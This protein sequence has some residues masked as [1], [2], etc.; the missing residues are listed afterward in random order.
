MKAPTDNGSIN[1][2]LKYF[3]KIKT[4][5]IAI[6][7]LPAGFIENWRERIRIKEKRERLEAEIIHLRGI[8]RNK[9]DSCTRRGGYGP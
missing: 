5:E 4:I 9:F 8:L 2:I 3:D 6:E 7:S 1:E